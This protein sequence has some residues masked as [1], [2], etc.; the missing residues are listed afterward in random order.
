MA[1][2][3]GSSRSGSNGEH[4]SRATV[5]EAAS[6]LHSAPRKMSRHVWFRCSGATRS[7]RLLIG[8]AKHAVYQCR[9]H[10]DRSGSKPEPEQSLGKSVRVVLVPGRRP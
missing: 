5:H 8:G 9:A 10:P 3:T 7:W 4:E 1:R 6:M 2:I